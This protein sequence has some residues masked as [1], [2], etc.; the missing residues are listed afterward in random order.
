MSCANSIQQLQVTFLVFT[1]D[2]EAMLCY[3]IE[4]YS[5]NTE[6]YVIYCTKVHLTE[7][8]LC[9]KWKSTW[10]Q[11]FLESSVIWQYIDQVKRVTG[12]FA[13]GSGE[14]GGEG[15]QQQPKPN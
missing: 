12:W 2:T 15:Q 8:P 11:C 14:G 3:Y 13:V 6:N 9:V 5:R 4:V 7:E 1:V 10:M